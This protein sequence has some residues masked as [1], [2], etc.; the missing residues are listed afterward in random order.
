[1]ELLWKKTRS[2]NINRIFHR[3][4]SVYSGSRVRFLLPYNNKL[5]SFSY[6]INDYNPCEFDLISIKVN[7]HSFL[8]QELLIKRVELSFNHSHRNC[9]VE[10]NREVHKTQSIIVEEKMFV[11]MKDDKLKLMG[12]SMV[13]ATKEKEMYFDIVANSNANKMFTVLRNK[14]QPLEIVF[15]KHL[16]VGLNQQYAV[17]IEVNTKITKLTYSDV[18]LIFNPIKLLLDG[19]YEEAAEI[20][21]ELDMI[22]EDGK[23][24]LS[25]KENNLKNFQLFIKFVKK[26]SFSLQTEVRYTIYNN[27]KPNDKH[28]IKF[29]KI[30]TIDV[31]EALKVETK[32]KSKIKQNQK[33]LYVA[34]TGDN[35]TVDVSVTNLLPRQI[36]ISEISIKGATTVTDRQSEV[37]DFIGDEAIYWIQSKSSNSF[38]FDVTVDSLDSLLALELN[39]M[40]TCEKQNK[41]S[42]T[43]L[44]KSLTDISFVNFP[45]SVASFIQNDE[46]A[47]SVRNLSS[48]HSIMLLNFETS[49]D[50]ILSGKKATRLALR[51]NREYKNTFPIFYLN[52]AAALP[53]LAITELSVDPNGNEDQKA[54]YL[55]NINN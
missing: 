32:Y 12:I 5:F 17:D 27:E 18:Y 47:I 30:A 37:V 34:A 2:R 44:F 48:N 52:P 7:I 53:Y 29:I 3:L 22:E 54:H 6:E 26:H 25:L 49:P 28:I 43:F 4:L 35:L 1:M 16:V 20:S 33:D 40:E 19:K 55:I 11:K 42:P 39:W 13:L 46:L 8:S 36:K 51:S 31:I 15:P 21:C 10:L 9:I 45:Y 38:T 41:T 50:I 14:E 23:K 24:I